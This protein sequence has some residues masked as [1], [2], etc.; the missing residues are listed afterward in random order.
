MVR[1][2]VPDSSKWVA[3]LCCNI[4]ADVLGPEVFGRG[5]KVLRV[6]GDPVDVEADRLG[7]QVVEDQVLGRAA[8]QR[9]HGQLLCRR[10]ARTRSLSATCMIEDG[11]RVWAG[12]VRT[13][14]PGQRGGTR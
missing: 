12:S 2:S 10:D 8:A 9:S 5:V 13:E 3:K 7:R 4:R 6:I 14:A 11:G 1:R